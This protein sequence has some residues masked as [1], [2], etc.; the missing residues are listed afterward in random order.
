MVRALFVY[1]LVLSSVVDRWGC[2]VAEFLSH[3]GSLRKIWKVNTT[4]KTIVSVFFFFNFNGK[5][6]YLVLPDQKFSVGVLTYKLLPEDEESLCYSISGISL[7]EQMWIETLILFTS[8]LS[9]RM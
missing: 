7:Q 3:T 2:Q 5:L 1:L 9:L 8:D 6:N 4:K